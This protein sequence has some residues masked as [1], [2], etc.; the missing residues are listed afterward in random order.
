MSRKRS[1]PSTTRKHPPKTDGR[2]LATWK[3]L[4]PGQS[5]EIGHAETDS[6]LTDRITSHT[7][8]YEEFVHPIADALKPW[9]CSEIEVLAKVREAIDDVVKDR[10]GQ[11]GL[12]DTGAR[13]ENKRY[14]QSLL[15][16]VNK[17]RERL[18]AVSSGFLVSLAAQEL[19]TG[20]ATFRN[21][22]VEAALPAFFACL[23]AH[24]E[25]PRKELIELSETLVKLAAQCNK[26]IR[27]PA[28]PPPNS[29]VEK[30]RTAF[31]ALFLMLQTTKKSPTAGNRNTPFCLIA[32]L[33]FEAATGQR[34][35]NLERACKYALRTARASG[36]IELFSKR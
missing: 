26:S 32:S 34:D 10:I 13:Q 28:G 18:A 25:K 4:Q 5:F 8:Q 6:A 14:A 17:L 11:W 33:L 19:D 23:D 29:G 22:N 24:E 27:N 2:P 21:E 15:D 12:F 31:T 16:D 35:P 3:Q 36:F 9:N 30:I 20:I 1:A 7:P